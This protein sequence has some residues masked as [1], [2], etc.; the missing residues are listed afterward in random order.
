MKMF[1]GRQKQTKQSGYPQQVSEIGKPFEV[2]HNVHVG[3]NIATGKIEGLPAP[4]VSLINGANITPAEQANNPE[5]VLN[6]LK[7]VTYNETH[8]DKFIAN[9]DTINQELE[10]IEGT[11][12]RSK[13]NS[14]I[15]YDDDEQSPPGSANSSSELLDLNKLGMFFLSFSLL[16]ATF[17]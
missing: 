10:E 2:R 4:W 1:T 3:F 12:P 7:L 8:K 15:A 14:R 16:V 9:Q 5:A 11:W 13:E 17:F 6:A